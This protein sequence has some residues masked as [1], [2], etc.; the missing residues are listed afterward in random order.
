MQ[1]EVGGGILPVKS[2]R[3]D[4]IGAIEQRQN[5]IGKAELA[6][7]EPQ[8]DRIAIAEAGDGGRY[9]VGAPQRQCLAA[10]GEPE[11]GDT[12][13]RRGAYG[14]STIQTQCAAA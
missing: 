8:V 2:Q 14:R 3:L 1:L 9:R 7:R 10:A 12:E 4:L 11:A 5:M 6:D 13:A